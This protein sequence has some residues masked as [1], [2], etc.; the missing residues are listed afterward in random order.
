MC[1]LILHS[2]TQL[3]ASGLSGKALACPWIKPSQEWTDGF[4]YLSDTAIWPLS[5]WT[6]VRETMWRVHTPYDNSWHCFFLMCVL[7]DSAL[8]THR[9]EGLGGL[10]IIS[11]WCVSFLA[12]LVA[13]SQD[14]AGPCST[15]VEQ[16]WRRSAIQGWALALGTTRGAVVFLHLRNK[17]NTDPL[18]RSWDCPTWPASWSA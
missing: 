7:L 16:R 13:P 10:Y 12:H 6:A 3:C 17:P 9:D 8:Q 2:N 14:C 11:T 4:T 1:C 18:R 5:L 15:E